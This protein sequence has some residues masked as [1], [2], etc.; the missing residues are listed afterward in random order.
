M[1]KIIVETQMVVKDLSFKTLVSGDKKAEIKLELLF[2]DRKAIKQL[3]NL[4]DKDVVNVVIS[5]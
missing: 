2:D 4:A 1:D 5:E 3:R